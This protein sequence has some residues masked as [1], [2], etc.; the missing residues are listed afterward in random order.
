[1]T[2]QG[3]GARGR[4]VLAVVLLAAGAVI[5][6]A[7]P[8][9]GATRGARPALIAAVLCVAL[10]LVQLAGR[11]AADRPGAEQRAAARSAYSSALE[12]AVLR[13]WSAVTAVHWPEF[14]VVAVLVLEVLHPFSGWHTAVLGL[15]LIGFLLA[16]HLA[17]SDA[18]P[19]ILRAQL[20][21]LIAAAGLAVLS[22][23]A[24]LLPAASAGPAWLTAVAAVAAVIAAGLALPV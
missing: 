18:G 2:G 8:M 10:S 11:V 19:G 6:A 15:V 23:G 14:A 21:L 17:E 4:A 7:V 12:D 20:P 5:W 3:Q 1:M 24:G 22:A 13:V 16:L 9:T